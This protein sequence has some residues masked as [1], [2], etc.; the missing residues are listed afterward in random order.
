MSDRSV[1]ATAKMNL[2]EPAVARSINGVTKLLIRVAIAAA[3]VIAVAWIWRLGMAWIG[4]NFAWILVQVPLG[5]CTATL[6]WQFA[7]RHERLWVAP[8]CR[9]TELMDEVRAGN[10]P[11][12]SLSEISGPVAPL[13][14]QIQTLLRDLRCQEQARFRLQAEMKQRVRTRTDALEGKLAVW[15]THAYRDPLTGLYNR[16]LLDEQ[17]PKLIEQC[18]AVS[19]PLCVVSMD[20]DNF[21]HLN[22]KQGH[23]A[24]D[25]ILRDVGQLIRSSLRQSDLAFRLG[26]D[27]FLLLLPGSNLQAAQHLATRLIALV[28]QLATTLRTDRKVGLSAGVICLDDLNGLKVGDILEQADA[29]MYE[30][31]SERKAGR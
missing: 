17:L 9:L 28:D 27:E 12:E 19:S 29:A 15:Q 23:A 24:G 18:N 31:K 5:A 10:A 2:I 3:G 1:P 11:I 16:R 30:V 8:V 26:G 22:D 7:A 21:K 14:R 4:P 13:A 25:K 20:L 6:A